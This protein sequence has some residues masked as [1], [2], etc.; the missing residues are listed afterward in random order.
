MLRLQNKKRYLKQ[1][2]QETNWILV[3]RRYYSFIANNRNK[4]LSEKRLWEEKTALSLC[5]IHCNP[6]GF[7]SDTEC[8]WNSSCYEKSAGAYFISAERLP[9]QQRVIWVR[10]L[11]KGSHCQKRFGANIGNTWPKHGQAYK[12]WK[13]CR[14][15]CKPSRSSQVWFARFV[16]TI[17]RTY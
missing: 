16:F 4:P 14:L 7:S 8:K 6:W 3:R 13:L 2:I 11:P 17:G 5:K 15:S 12:P 9:R 10:R 1:S